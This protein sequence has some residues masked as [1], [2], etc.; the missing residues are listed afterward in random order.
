MSRNQLL[1]WLLLALCGWQGWRHWQLRPVQ[2][3]DGVLSTDLPQ[4]AATTLTPF[5]H[6]GATFTPRA[7]Y[8]L[9][10]RLLARTPY[11]MGRTADYSP[12]DFAIGWGAMSDNR[13]LDMLEFNPTNRFFLLRWQNQPPV[14][15]AELFSSLSNNH[16][17]AA[18][19]EVERSLARMRPG[20]VV[21]LEG[22]LVDIDAPDG[23]HWRTSL[24]RTDNGGGACEV[25]FVRHAQIILKGN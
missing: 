20:Q 23:W 7:A 17:I 3:P 5:Q 11:R 2:Q 22:E 18:T 24:I 16:V 21:E 19:A 15:E 1:L 14:P 10:G 12:L 13:V 8:R 9:R 6:L 25:L 4:Q